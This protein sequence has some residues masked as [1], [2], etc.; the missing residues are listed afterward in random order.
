MSCIGDQYDIRTSLMTLKTTTTKTGKN[1]K[2]SK[3]ARKDRSHLNRKLFSENFICDPLKVF[4]K[5]IEAVN[6]KI[7]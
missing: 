5:P 7:M 6:I 2:F 1:Q 3:K 4:V